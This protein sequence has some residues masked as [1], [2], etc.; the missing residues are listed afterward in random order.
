MKYMLSWFYSDNFTYIGA[1]WLVFDVVKLN[2]V[3]AR[4]L[5]G[6]K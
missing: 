5:L 2:V 4:L 6:T 3:C 1:F